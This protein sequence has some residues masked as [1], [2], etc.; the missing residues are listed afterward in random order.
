MDLK[1]KIT[2][3]EGIIAQHKEVTYGY[4]GFSFEK[5]LGNLLCYTLFYFIRRVY[6]Y[7]YKMIL[8]LINRMPIENFHIHI[9]IRTNV[10]KK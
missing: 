2:E 10:Y 5:C 9:N 7:F 1:A 6:G 8:C 3:L 4:L